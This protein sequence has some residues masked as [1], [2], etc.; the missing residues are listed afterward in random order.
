MINEDTFMS[1]Q[2][3]MNADIILCSN[4]SFPYTAAYY[5]D[6]RIMIFR[7]EVPYLLP[8]LTYGQNSADGYI[9]ANI[10]GNFDEKLLQICLEN[11]I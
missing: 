7:D 3:I 9:Y 8:R 5:S 1:F 2:T 6:A 11:Y 4:S 10:N